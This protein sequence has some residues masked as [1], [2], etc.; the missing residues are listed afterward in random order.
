[1]SDD[2]RLFALYKLHKVDAKLHELKTR[3]GNLDVGKEEIAQFKEL[4]K[5][6]KELLAAAEAY[7]SNVKGLENKLVETNLKKEKYEKQLYDGT[8]SNPREV[9][10]LQ[11]EVE[12]LTSLAKETEDKLHQAKGEKSAMLDPADQVIAKLKELKKAI[13]IKQKRAKEEHQ[14]LQTEFKQVADSRPAVAEGVEPELITSYTVAR[15]STNG[16]GMALVLDSGTCSACGNP[17]PARNTGLIREGKVVNCESCR[18][19]LFI[20]AEET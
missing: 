2:S 15:K 1:M 4:E 5:D 14:S 7:K 11:K 12:M 19:I 18:R 9:E 10:N 20:L 8:V 6:S 3:A 17:V 16:T 13:L